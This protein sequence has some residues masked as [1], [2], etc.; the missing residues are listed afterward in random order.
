MHF[1]HGNAAIRTSNI[2]NKKDKEIQRE[3][4]SSHSEGHLVVGIFGTLY[5][6]ARGRQR[7]HLLV[8]HCCQATLP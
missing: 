2:N 7:A 1:L 4:C 3:Q 8:E 6:I 5:L